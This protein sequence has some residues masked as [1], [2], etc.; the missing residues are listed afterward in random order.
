[1]QRMDST[2][3]DELLWVNVKNPTDIKNAGVMKQI[4]SHT[5]REVRRKERVSKPKSISTKAVN[6]RTSKGIDR[7]PQ[8]PVKKIPLVGGEKKKPLEK[9]PAGSV[10]R[11][12][13]IQNSL[14]DLAAETLL[15]PSPPLAIAISP[16]DPV[17]LNQKIYRYLSLWQGDRALQLCGGN[18]HG[19]W[20]YWMPTVLTNNTMMHAQAFCA[21]THFE[22]WGRQSTSADTWALKDQAVMRVN[23]NLGNPDFSQNDSNV[24][25]VLCLAF[26]SHVEVSLSPL[27]KAKTTLSMYS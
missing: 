6:R 10:D 25:S 8:L 27:Q 22:F 15:C 11:R 19:R 14:Q 20:E 24:A 26:A 21:A 9:R 4:R 5:Q 2:S 23:K 12:T 7:S 18:V 3:S 1:M 16:R 13:V 17:R